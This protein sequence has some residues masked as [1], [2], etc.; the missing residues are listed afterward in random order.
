MKFEIINQ[1]DK[2]VMQTGYVE[3]I[4]DKETIDFMIRGRYKFKIDGK[5]VSKK[6]I[7]EIRGSKWEKLQSLKKC[8]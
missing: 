2:T 3:C 5:I 6:K 1:E 4:P 7:D 8:L